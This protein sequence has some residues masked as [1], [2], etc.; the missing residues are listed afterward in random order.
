[1]YVLQAEVM[2]LKAAGCEAD[3]AP[4]AMM[5]LGLVYQTR[6]NALASNGDLIGAKQAA[7]DSV[8]YIDAAKPLLEQLKLS[9]SSEV[10]EYIA[11]YGPLRLQGYRLM[12]Q[13]FA[14]LQDYEAC[15]KEFRLATETFP[16]EASSWQ[17]L[18]RILEL[19][20]K[21]EEA[22]AAMG[23]AKAIMKDQGAGM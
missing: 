5:N 14:G 3:V 15:E 1:M 22:Q 13:I 20:G 18:Y 16:N 11:R 9:G 12:G 6:A 4:K 17:M 8:K 19:Q 10:D 21:M 23:K 2:F 7:L